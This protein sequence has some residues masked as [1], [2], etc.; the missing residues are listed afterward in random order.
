MIPIKRRSE[1]I[2]ATGGESVITLSTI[3]IP[4]ADSERAV[5]SVNGKLQPQ[6]SYT[7]DSATQ[8]TLSENLELN[9]LVEVFVF[10]R[11]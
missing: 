5:V 8:I 4:G 6:T 11:S 9:D 3:T 7:V 10:G 2:T 1:E